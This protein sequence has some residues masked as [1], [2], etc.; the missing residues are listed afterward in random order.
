M[1]I[2]QILPRTGGF[3]GGLGEPD[4]EILKKNLD[5]LRNL[6]SKSKQ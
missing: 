4:K 5:C 1:E 3:G 6:P 2:A